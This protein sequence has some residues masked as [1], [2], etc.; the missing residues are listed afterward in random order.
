MKGLLDDVQIYGR[1]L[2]DAEIM[3][4]YTQQLH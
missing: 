4:L 2:S 3:Q 1:A